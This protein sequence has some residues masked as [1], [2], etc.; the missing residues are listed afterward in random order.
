MESETPAVTSQAESVASPVAESPT[1]PIAN[2]NAQS[3]QETEKYQ[4]YLTQARAQEA[5]LF[6]MNERYGGVMEIIENNGHGKPLLVIVACRYTN[7]SPS[8]A[9]PVTSSTDTVVTNVQVTLD[10]ASSTN[11]DATS[12]SM[13]PQIDSTSS[14]YESPSTLSENDSFSSH[15]L[16][17][18]FILLMNEISHQDY[19][20]V[21]Y[22][23]GISIASLGF[24]PFWFFKECY[25]VLPRRYKKNVFS[26]SIVH[27]GFWVRSMFMLMR[28]FL[29]AKF[30]EKLYY[31]D[32]MEELW[33][34][35][36]MTKAVWNEN[37]P[38]EAVNYEKRMAEE[39]KE[40]ASWFPFVAYKSNP[41]N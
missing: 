27:P 13:V 10:S 29:S 38:I 2:E 37:Q 23:T 41:E 22:Q 6:A 17:L 3:D 24:L 15:D 26:M 21:F 20:V 4:S 34:D 12:G 1:D 18:L 5:R 28:P 16:F 40:Y 33:L 25:D 19:C 36:I 32:R 31:M 14:S 35:D 7:Y 9:G 8:Q 39:M 11:L 30:W